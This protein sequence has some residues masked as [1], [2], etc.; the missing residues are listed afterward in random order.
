MRSVTKKVL[1]L[2]AALRPKVTKTQMVTFQSGPENVTAF[3]ASIGEPG[4][5]RAVIAIH[6][7]WGLNDWVKEQATN[8]ASNGYV[9]LAVDLYQG[10]VTVS[11][12]EARKP[13]RGLR[14]DLVIRAM[15]AAF[16]YLAGRPDVDPQHIGSIE[17]S[18]GGGYALQLTIHEPRLAACVVN[19]GALPT[20]PVD[21]QSINA[22]VLGTFGALDR[23]I[24]PKKVRAFEQEMNA[25]N[26][27]VD[28]KIY[29]D[30]GHAFENPAN[31]RGYRPELTA[32]AWSRT[33]TFLAQ[34]QAAPVPRTVVAERDVR[35]SST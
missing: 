24:P 1:F 4:R 12:V 19:Y 16:D 28:M 15:R 26:K 17:W 18:M 23:G 13:K 7:W 32:D 20:D 14:Q 22:Q 30:A 2:T 34:A 25:V 35:D 33:V 10:T 9:V 29:H 11:P 31:T 21:L 5:Q 8:L 6:E 27:S 3:L